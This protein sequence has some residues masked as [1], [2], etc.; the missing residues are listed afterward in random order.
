MGHLVITT[1]D[2]DVTISGDNRAASIVVVLEDF[3]HVGGGNVIDTSI[4]FI[5]R[6]TAAEV[7]DLLADVFEGVG[8]TILVEEELSLQVDLSLVEFLVLDGLLREACPVGHGV[9]DDIVDGVGKIGTSLVGAHDEVLT[10]ETSIFV[11]VEEGLSGFGGGF[12]EGGDTSGTEVHGGEDLSGTLDGVLGEFVLRAVEL[13]VDL[14]GE[15]ESSVVTR[16]GTHSF[17]GPGDVASLHAEVPETVVTT[18]VAGVGLDLV[19]GAVDVTEV[20]LTHLFEFSVVDG[21]RTDEEHAGTSEVSLAEFS[22]VSFRDGG[23]TLS[24]TVDGE[25]EATILSGVVGADVEVVHDEVINEFVGLV[26]GE[27][28]GLLGSLDVFGGEISVADHFGEDTNGLLDVF[29]RALDGEVSVFTANLGHE[30]TTDFVDGGGEGLTVLTNGTVEGSLHEDLHET[31]VVASFAL[32]TDVEVDTDGGE[33]GVG[34]FFSGNLNTV[35]E[36]RDGGGRD[37]SKSAAHSG[38]GGGD[39]LHTS[40]LGDGRERDGH[41]FFG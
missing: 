3:H 15:L 8:G 18:D 38:G 17:D 10:E 41:F 27:F 12:G 32:G 23:D 4:H 19:V 1:E 9:L 34:V 37:V 33:L 40:L 14:S 39:G 29:A 28:S 31:V 24:S 20:L 36:G 21:T 7:E 22:E 25:T 5:K 13:T 16:S 35:L 6:N 26:T 11:L 2:V 30:V